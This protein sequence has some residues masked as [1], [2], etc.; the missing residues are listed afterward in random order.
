[1]Y[2]TWLVHSQETLSAF[3]PNVKGNVAGSD[4]VWQEDSPFD[5]A[6]DLDY[7]DEEALLA[8]NT[9]V[10]MVFEDGMSLS[11]AKLAQVD[12]AEQVFVQKSHTLAM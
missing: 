1:M 3:Y 9:E 10:P 2:Q 5:T 6:A 7:N 8:T 12:I 4:I 11:T